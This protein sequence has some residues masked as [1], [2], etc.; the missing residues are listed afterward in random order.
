MAARKK[1]PIATSLADAF[2]KC[3]A[4]AETR[5]RP[6]KVMA[7]LMG[8]SRAT[9]ARWTTECEMPTNRI[10]QFETLCGA[11]AVSDWLAIADGTRMVIDMA[12]G[13]GS[14]PQDVA[15]LQAVLHEAVGQIIDFAA[16]KTTAQAAIAAIQA[17]IAELVSHKANIEKHSQPELEFH[18]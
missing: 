6:A 2:E 18:E 9:Y 3:E 14:K 11:T 7:E 15:A 1:S 16:R 13:R 8:V 10:R 12:T 5:R 17:A 4:V